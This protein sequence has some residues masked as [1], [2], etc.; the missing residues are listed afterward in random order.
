MPDPDKLMHKMEQENEANHQYIERENKQSQSEPMKAPKMSKQMIVNKDMTIQEQHR[1]Q[2]NKKG[3]KDFIIDT[4]EQVDWFI[5]QFVAPEN[6][7]KS[8]IQ[9]RREKDEMI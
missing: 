2:E 1:V 3:K 9:F 7:R 8:H 4:E 5:K 6:S